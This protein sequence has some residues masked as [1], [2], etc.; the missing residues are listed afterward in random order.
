MSGCRVRV[1]SDCCCG[2]A[3]KHPGVD[4]AGLRARLA[5]GLAGHAEVDVTTCLLA[6]EH[7]DV[8]VVSPC[9]AARVDGARPLWLARVLDAA[10]VDAVVAWVRAGGPGRAPLPTALAPHVV[11]PPSLAPVVM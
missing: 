5:A 8:V 9:A 3:T 2:S 7:S 1:C 6:C 10:L 11:A 4:H